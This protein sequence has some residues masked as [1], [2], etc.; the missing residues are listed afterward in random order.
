MGA[1]DTDPAERLG[2]VLSVRQ[3]RRRWVGDRCARQAGIEVPVSS[4]ACTKVSG[5]ESK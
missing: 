2:R 5:T 1:W 4:S 3:S